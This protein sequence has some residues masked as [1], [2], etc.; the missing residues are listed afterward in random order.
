[1]GAVRMSYPYRYELYKR[2]DE[3]SGK[4]KYVIV[5]TFPKRPT[6]DEVNEVNDAFQGKEKQRENSFRRNLG[7][8]EW[9]ILTP[10]E[11]FGSSGNRY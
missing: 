1:M 8:L 2:V 7:F 6:I 11:I 10:E 9:D 3:P 5:A 4:E